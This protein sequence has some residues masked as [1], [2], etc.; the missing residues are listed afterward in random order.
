MPFAESHKRRQARIIRDTRH[1]EGGERRR[2]GV[3]HRVGPLRVLR[4]YIRGRKILVSRASLQV[5]RT[6]AARGPGKSA[7]FARL[8]IGTNPETTA[9]RV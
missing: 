6:L 8:A 5:T 4:L 2:P 9:Y 7:I 1:I 3:L